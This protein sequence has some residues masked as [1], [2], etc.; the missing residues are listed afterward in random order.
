MAG[1]WGVF[2]K[3]MG[4][5]ALRNFLVFVDLKKSKD[6]LHALLLWLS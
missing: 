2:M 5:K 1:D 4:R 6:E 3:V